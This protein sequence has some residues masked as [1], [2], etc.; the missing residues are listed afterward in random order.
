M[1]KVYDSDEILKMAV[2]LMEP[3]VDNADYDGDGKI[4]ASDARTN[5]RI[6]SGKSIDTPVVGNTGITGNTGVTGSSAS[7]GNDIFAASKAYQNQADAIY[8]RIQETP[9]F[10]YDFNEDAVFQA[11]REQYMKDGNLAAK[12]VA[13]QAAALS[14]GYGNSYGATAAA[15]AYMSGIDDLYDVIPELESAAYGRYRD[16]RADALQNWEILQNRADKERAYAE[17]EREYA[18]SREAYLWEQALQKAEIGDY[19]GLQALG[20]NTE[21]REYAENLNNALTLAGIGD[22]SGLEALGI[23]TSKIKKQSDLD[24]AL[25]AAD[26]GDYSFL[27]ALGIDTSALETPTYTYRSGGY[28]GGKVETKD[29]SEEDFTEEGSVNEDD[30]V[31]D[32]VDLKMDELLRIINDPNSS[33][34]ERTRAEKLYINLARRNGANI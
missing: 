14:G 3:D 29:D 10:T 28:G 15:Q 30:Y 19:S 6:D 16:K 17:G 27:K 4:T 22:Y 7:G 25:A 8:Q 9:E 33:D 1:K 12:N 13:G 24:F 11:L 5:K 23:D 20:I 21:K 18:D 26:V 31:M 32:D 2:G 34:A